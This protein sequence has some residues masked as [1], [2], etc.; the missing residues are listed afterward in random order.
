[1][2]APEFA[3]L[4]VHTEFSLLDGANRI[5]DL[6]RA[7]KADGQNALAITDHGNMFGAVDLYKECTAQDIRPILGCEMYVARQS[8]HKPHSKAKG[9]GYNH[10]TLLARNQEGYRN[11]IQ[12]ASLAYTEGFHYRPRIDRELLSQ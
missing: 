6:V 8:R 2:T 12:L 3:H 1:M 4:H 9:N 7:C 11:L 10:I 5:P